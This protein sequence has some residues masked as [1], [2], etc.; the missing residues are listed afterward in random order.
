MPKASE[1]S[2]EDVRAALAHDKSILQSVCRIIFSAIYLGFF[3]SVLFTHIPT[4]RMYDEAYAVYSILATSGGDAVTESSPMKFFNIGQLSD[5]FD[6][7]NNSFV[8]SVFVTQDQN[9]YDLDA[10]DYARIGLFNKALGGV[11]I[12]VINRESTDCT[13]DNYLYDLYKECHEDP[14]SDFRYILFL[15]LNATEASQYLAEWKAEDTW[16][17]NSTDKAV[18]SVLTYNGELEGYVVTELTLTLNQGG[19]VTPT[20]LARPTISAPY[21]DQSSYASDILVWICMAASNIWAMSRVLR[22]RY[23]EKCPS[24]RDMI[25]RVFSLFSVEV[26]LCVFY[27][28]WAT[29]VSLLHNTDFQESI[30]TYADP[31]NVDEVGSAEAISSLISVIGDLESIAQYTEALRVIGAIV[32]ALLC[33]QILNRFRFHPQLNI[34]TRTVASALT[35]FGAFFVVFIVIFTGFTIIGSMIFGD[36][37]KEFSSLVNSMASCINML[38]GQFNFDSIKNVSFSV[39]FYWSYMIVVGI[40]LM[41]MMLAIVLDA[42]DQV[43]KESY[44]KA[45]NLKLASRVS[46]ICWDMVCELRIVLFVRK[47]VVSRGKIRPSELER[48]LQNNKIN[49]KV[50]E[51]SMKDMFKHTGPGDEAIRATLQYIQEGIEIVHVNALKSGEADS[52]G[53]ETITTVN[54]A[55]KMTA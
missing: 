9:G 27:A 52:N 6:W 13:P 10:E 44:R 41:N 8:P 35:Q 46:S 12:R 30:S 15:S 3:T 29:I 19:F 21:G 7:L 38:F 22:W 14:V 34:L 33:L 17:N 53:E 55:S 4:S 43:S 26:V 42:Y 50:T 24:R 45:A 54:V 40:V 11:M 32:I 23:K 39:A 47:T 16:I 2:L 49:Q 36:H 51:E 48:A 28:V 25:I 18:I 31:F 20:A 1:L 37:A 5:A